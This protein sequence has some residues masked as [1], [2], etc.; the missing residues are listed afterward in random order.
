LLGCD[1]SRADYLD[2]AFDREHFGM[3]LSEVA[4]RT[5]L[6]RATARRLLL[7]LEG[8]CSIA[9]PVRDASGGALAALNV[10]MPFQ[11]GARARAVKEVLPLLRAKAQRIERSLPAGPTASAVGELR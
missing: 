10:G 8:L 4:E 1:Y 5:N 9:V 6:S 2:K 3:T 11:Q 7:T